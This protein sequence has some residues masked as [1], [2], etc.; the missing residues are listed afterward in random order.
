MSFQCV[1]QCADSSSGELAT[2]SQPISSRL[3]NVFYTDNPSGQDVVFT[4]T[5]VYTVDVVVLQVH[6]CTH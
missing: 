5:Q 6:R 2:F 1:V 3:I 4:G